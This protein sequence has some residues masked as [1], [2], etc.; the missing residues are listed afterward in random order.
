[1]LRNISS[2]FHSQQECWDSQHWA[3]CSPWRGAGFC[4]LFPLWLF[5]HLSS[6][7]HVSSCN[8][9]W[10]LACR[11]WQFCLHLLS[12]FA[13]CCPSSTAD[14]KPKESHRAASQSVADGSSTPN[15]EG[16]KH[17]SLVNTNSS[18][19]LQQLQL[20]QTRIWTTWDSF[21]LRTTC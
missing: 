19:L 1:M 4:P 16:A 20:D 6:S 17:T 12:D 13:S 14:K 15:P 9:P 7:I 2:K 5:H 11:K 10:A 8:V 18:V 3:S 21:A